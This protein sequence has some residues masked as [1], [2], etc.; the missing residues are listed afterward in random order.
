M[1]NMNDMINRIIK[2]KEEY[3][4]VEMSRHVS[5]EMARN[6]NDGF[7][8]GGV[9]PFGYQIAPVVLNK[10]RTRKKL[11][12]HQNEAVIVQSAF[13]RFVQ[14]GG[15]TKALCEWLNHHNHRTRKGSLWTVRT[16]R[17][18]LTNPVYK[19]DYCWNVG[20][21]AA[22]RVVGHAPPIVSNET[23]DAVQQLVWAATR[24]R[25]GT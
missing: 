16:T 18:L 11:V 15:E 5:C 14:E 1:S 8:N 22:N 12:P 4:A 9:P 19:G 23:F 2:L 13:V 17:K 3:D 24:R 21:T 10:F 25:S 20:G 6:A 7:F